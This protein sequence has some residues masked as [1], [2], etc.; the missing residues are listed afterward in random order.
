MLD[1]VRIPDAA[2][3]ARRYP[4][5]FSAGMR[6]RVMIAMALLVQPRLL[7]LLDRGAGDALRPL[8]ALQRDHYVYGGRFSP[9]GGAISYIS[10]LDDESGEVIAGAILYRHDL[11][12]G[13]RR[14]L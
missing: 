10:D 12:S 2:S 4:H 9:D 5:E 11:A 1:R 6:Q 13:E 3:R 14:V 8:T 7:L